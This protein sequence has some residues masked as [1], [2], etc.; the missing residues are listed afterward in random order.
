MP[1]NRS[2][3]RPNPK[4]AKRL[5]ALLDFHGMTKSELARRLGVTPSSVTQWIQGIT[6][7]SAPNALKI[8][9]LFG[10]DVEFVMGRL[11]RG[12]RGL[13]ATTWATDTMLGGELMKK[14]DLLSEEERADI[15]ALIAAHLEAKP[16]PPN[17]KPLPKKK[18]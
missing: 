14:L 13:G 6:A 3:V 9:E 10:E 12:S 17:E 7:L 5:A 2:V 11:D 8:A 16:A 18:I 1:T 15:R 4:V